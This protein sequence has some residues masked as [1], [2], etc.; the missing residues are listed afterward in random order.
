[1]RWVPPAITLVLL[2][3]L[4]AH[5]RAYERTDDAGAFHTSARA[6]LESYPQRIGAWSGTEI[7]VPQAAR[8]LLRPNALLS[9]EFRKD[10]STKV[11]SVVVVQCKDARD[12]GAHYPP[13]C[14]PAS[15]WTLDSTRGPMPVR[16]GDRDIQFVRYRFHRSGFEA[17]REIVVY[18]V[19]A[20]PGHGLATDLK[21]V[22]RAASDY[23][24]RPFGAAQV[25]V[26]MPDH[27]SLE[28]EHAV[29]GELL[30]PLGPALE[31]LVAG[32]G[33]GAR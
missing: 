4:F 1:M 11:A 2:L 17:Y 26:L 3:G 31:A 13:V 29:V 19:F 5:A 32:A 7:A 18:S 30:A 10:G 21:D 22:R 8:A 25:Q 24:S 20:L 14:Y 23:L 15:G 33:G 12:M 16:V 27:D 9:R 28:Q 6:A